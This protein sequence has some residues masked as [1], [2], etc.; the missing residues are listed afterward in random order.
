L[1]TGR[2]W[3]WGLLP[4]CCLCGCAPVDAQPAA[5]ALT[6]IAR[7]D[8]VPYQR[9]SAGETLN[10]GVVAFSR[11]GIQQ[12]SYTVSGQGYGGGPLVGTA[13][14]RNPQSGVWEYFAPLPA[15]SFTSD[16]PIAVTAVVTGR[17]GGAR[18][19]EPLSL[20][21]NP[22]NTLPRPE[23]WVATTGD[24]A[25]GAVNNSAKPFKTPLKAIQAIRNWKNAGGYGNNA[26]GGIVRLN[27]GAHAWNS[28][29]VSD[30]FTCPNEWLIITTAAGGTTANT[31]LTGGTGAGNI[32]RLLVRGITVSGRWVINPTDAYFHA[33]PTACCWYDQCRCLGGGQWN[34]NSYVVGINTPAAYQTDCTI[35]NCDFAV[36]TDRTLMA[37]GLTVTN[38]G[39]D[40]FQNVPL[41]V[42]CTVDNVDPGATG[43]HADVVGDGYQSN[44]WQSGGCRIVYNLRATNCHYQGIYCNCNYQSYAGQLNGQAFVNV[45]IELADPIRT[46]GGGSGYNLAVNHML[47]WNVALVSKRATPYSH[48]FWFHQDGSPEQQTN[49]TNLSVIGCCWDNLGISGTLLACDQSQ[50]DNNHFCAGT[51][52]GANPTTG[53][54]GLDPTSGKPLATSILRN[55]L[56]TPRV[57]IDANNSPRPNPASVGAYQP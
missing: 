14:A 6:P 35:S 34:S 22:R 44:L 31:T 32:E 42:N 48:G 29:N 12:V 4:I 10:L 41:V 11:S 30:S 43:W 1:Q 54:P 16:G 33:T 57:P 53:N 13:M 50:W 2:R 28:G 47:W 26:A 45:Y 19:L 25:T 18:T 15:S 55:R 39:N 46:G 7:W 37:R 17:D 52:R 24:D 21:V 38:I 9:I 49:M 23:A 8:V 51:T 5:D 56:T 20:V 40:A 27:P 36:M 3:L